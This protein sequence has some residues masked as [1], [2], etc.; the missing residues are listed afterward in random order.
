MQNPM[1]SVSRATI[2]TA[3]SRSMPMAAGSKRESGAAAG[4][5]LVCRVV[6]VLIQT[7]AGKNATTAA[8]RL[9]RKSRG[10]GPVIIMDGGAG[11]E[12]VADGLGCPARFGGLPGFPG[13]RGVV[14]RRAIH[15]LAGRHYLP[16][17]VANSV[18]AS[19]HGWTTPA[20]SA[21]IATRSFTFAILA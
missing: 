15:A 2:F 17:P 16:K 19:A 5:P 7:E 21:P 4:N 11:C 6:G 18:S 9:S 20:I 14:G 1:R 10:R 3:A 13:A 12:A 8:G